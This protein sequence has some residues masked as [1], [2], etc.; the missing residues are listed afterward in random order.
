MKFSNTACASN[1]LLEIIKTLGD[2][3]IGCEVGVWQGENLC[4]ILENCDNISKMYAV[5]QYKPYTDW[6]QEIDE[7]L[8]SYSKSI[9]NSNLA[10]ISQ[11]SKVTFL[12]LSS[13]DAITHITDGELDF[14][15]IDADHSYEHAYQ[16]FCNYFNKVKTNGIFAGHDY[17]LPGVNKALNQFL[18]EQNYTMEDLH[19]VTNDSWYI[20]KK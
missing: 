2:N 10:S 7:N 6:C 4:Q 11:S 17:S 14:I 8:I 5:D 3:I 9:A 1:G 15:F 19:R 13:E 20:I 16:D 12:E 18:P